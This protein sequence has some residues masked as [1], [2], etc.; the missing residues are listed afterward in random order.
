MDTKLCARLLHLDVRA[1]SMLGVERAFSQVQDRSQ[2]L[3]FYSQ[4]SMQFQ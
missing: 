3:Q 1:L 2:H 4:Q